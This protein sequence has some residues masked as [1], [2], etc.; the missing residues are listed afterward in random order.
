MITYG[1]KYHNI[2]SVP[3]QTKDWATLAP[4]PA[5]KNN[6]F[7]VDLSDLSG[8]LLIYCD[9]FRLEVFGF[10]LINPILKNF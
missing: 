7:I 2:Y 4:K 1:E 8:D 9:Y 3:S 6:W 5:M 10:M